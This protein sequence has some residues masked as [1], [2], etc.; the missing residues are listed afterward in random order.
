MKLHNFYKF[1]TINQNLYSSIINNE[2]YFS[3]PRNF[4][5]PFDSY[6]RIVITENIENLELFFNY[7]KAK[8][9][10]LESSIISNLKDQEKLQ[11]YIHSIFIYNEL[12]L[13]DEELY[14]YEI[15]NVRDKLI[16]LFAFYSENKNFENLVMKNKIFLQEKMY[17]DYIFLIIDNQNY[18]ITCGSEKANCPLMWGH[19]ADNH[20]GICIKYEIEN[21]S[22][23]FD[24]N[25]QLDILKVKYSDSPIN[26]FEYSFEE[27]DNL[28]FEILTNKY[29]KW[30]YENEIRLINK[31]QGL[32]K[33]NMKSI[34]EIIF[35]CR[36]SPKDRYSILKLFASL[37]YKIENLKIAKRLP[38]QYELSI[39]E[40]KIN[41]I[42]GSGV[43]I[44]ELNTNKNLR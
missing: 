37:G 21:N 44:E 14:A 42:A 18:G 8:I 17:Y 39:Q 25:K 34:S 3:N 4:N 5:D 22:I 24:K 38:N 13:L 12:N 29:S 41:D 23:T 6:P 9:V 28:K 43:Y 36:S 33:I 26:I 27:L 16:E 2:L 10:T 11:A 40:M 15:D 20:K 35:G 7:L 31:G 1:Y 19:Y 32:L 30:Q